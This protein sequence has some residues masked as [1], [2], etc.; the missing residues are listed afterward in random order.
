MDIEFLIE[1]LERYILVESPKFFGSRA[2]NDDEVRNQLTQI[3]QA[4]PEE[5]RKAQEIVAQRDTLLSEARG[6]AERILAA[7]RAESAELATEHRLVHE[8]RQQA[9]GIMR[10]AEQESVT[11]RA[12][13]DEY[14]FDSLSQLQAELTRILHVV[15]NGLQRLESDRERHL[16]AKE[17]TE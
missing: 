11:L 13:A 15:E 3:R 12:D 4:L 9:R 17:A 2:V 10:K 7:A 1:R 14:V 8:A 5:V 16:Q 6:E